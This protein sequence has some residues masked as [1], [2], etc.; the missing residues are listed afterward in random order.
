YLGRALG[1][2]PQLEIDYQN[3]PLE[4]GDT[5]L[6]VTDGVY[7]HVPARQLARTIRDGAA[8]LDAAAKSIVEQA[9]ENGSPDNLTAQIIRIDE[10][11]DGDA[12]E[13]FG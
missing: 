4:R 13:V 2:N 3:L 5:F 12:G 11:P 9:Y 7:E 1:V 6:L 10:L 8:D